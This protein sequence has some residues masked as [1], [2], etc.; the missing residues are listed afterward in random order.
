MSK[1][2]MISSVVPGLLQR[3]REL[4]AAIES[5]GT[6]TRT[7]ADLKVELDIKTDLLR[8]LL[9]AATPIKKSKGLAA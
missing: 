7:V 5:G 3:V 1:M 4:R 6:E 9:E 2:V 8:R